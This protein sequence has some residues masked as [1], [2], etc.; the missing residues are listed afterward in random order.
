MIKTNMFKNIV[1]YLFTCMYMIYIII[2][3]LGK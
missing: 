3:G 2:N 1:L